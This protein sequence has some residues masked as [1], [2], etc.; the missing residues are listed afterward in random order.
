M[1]GF[2]LDLSL[3]P[4]F[5][6]LIVLFTLLGAGL[7][8]I[9]GLIPGLHANNFAMLLAGIAPAVP[10]P[11]IF[12]GV[13]MLSA[14]IVHS[15]VDAVPALAIGV[16]DAD[17]AVMALPGHRLVIE[18]RGR[19]ALRLSALGSVLAVVMSIPLAI[20]LT[21]GVVSVYDYLMA[22]IQLL[23]ATVVVGLIVSEPTT[24][25]KIGGTCSFALATVLGLH[26][27]DAT[28]EAPLDAGGMLSPIFAGLFGAP[29][30][31][32]AAS[33]SGV[34][35][36]GTATLRTSRWL[37]VLTAA[38]GAV[39][40]AIVGFLPGISAA[41]AA[42]AVLAVM[43][44][45]SGDRGYVI[46]TSGVD[47]SNT[48]FALFALYAIGQPRSG[49]VVAYE[50]V[51]A[52]IE[53]GVLVLSTLVAGVIGYLSVVTIGDRYLSI[54]G[55]MDYARLSIALLL[56]LAGLSFLF[57]G[58]LG[59]LVYIISAAIGLV[60]VRIGGRRVHLM[61]VLIGPILLG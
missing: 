39:S 30:L 45:A 57:A 13:A 21:L 50:E 2:G 41:I 46:A 26:M 36:Q 48:I 9:S 17:M 27:L 6:A 15:F 47:T 44:G 24:R 31:L 28:P 10:A 16:P 51:G 49:I 25:A 12:V 43:P 5:T 32:D 61:G 38:A 8:V 56:A 18:G 7:G 1:F 53:L 34:P 55:S 29:V 52:P 23:L 35:R 14:G 33:G 22:N 54:I 59:V 37:L 60:P 20:P 40:G 4:Q 19:E 58:V 42:V 11:P 3:D